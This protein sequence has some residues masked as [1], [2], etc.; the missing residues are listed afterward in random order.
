MSEAGTDHS[1][2]FYRDQDL[3]KVENIATLIKAVLGSLSLQVEKRLVEHDLTNSQWVPLLPLARGQCRTVVELA[4]TGGSDPGAMTRAIDRLQSK[5]LVKRAR[6]IYD[7]RV[8]N[9]E[10]TASGRAAAA[11]VPALLAEVLN[12]HLAG[13]TATEWQNLLDLLRRMRAN[14]RTMGL[15][16]RDAIASQSKAHA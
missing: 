16:D 9:L 10:L 1:F 5:G 11:V 7:R 2:A 3:G 4:R 12:L 15:G 6:S 8:V 14:G 13:F